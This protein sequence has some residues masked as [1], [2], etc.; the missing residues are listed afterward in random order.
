V[1]QPSA[2]SSPPT[3]AQIVAAALKK[4]VADFG[5]ESGFKT[6]SHSKAEP[7]VVCDK[8]VDEEQSRKQ[9]SFN[10]TAKE[11]SLHKPSD[12]LF[13]PAAKEFCM[14]AGISQPSLNPAASE[15]W[16]NNVIEDTFKVADLFHFNPVA[17]EFTCNPEPHVCSFDPTSLNPMAPTFEPWMAPAAF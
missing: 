16:P 10:A 4:G 14:D 15:F 17:E 13:N 7:L 8:T 9:F 3:P 2:G 5:V 11:F 12:F 6:R 1:H